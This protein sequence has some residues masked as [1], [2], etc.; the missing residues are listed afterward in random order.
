M[1]EPRRP[2]KYPVEMRERAV[3]L[4]LEHQHEYVAV[5]GDQFGGS[6]DNYADTWRNTSKLALRALDGFLQEGGRAKVPVTLPSDHQSRI[7]V[8]Q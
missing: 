8:L 2:E 3:R 7:E 4:V 5:G 6:V 1:T